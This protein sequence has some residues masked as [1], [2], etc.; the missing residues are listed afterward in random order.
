MA[1]EGVTEQ[2]LERAKTYLTGAYPLRFDGNER[3][4]NILV[5][6][7]LDDMPIDYVNTRNDMVEAVTLDD[8]QRVAA[9]VIRPEDLH[10]VVVGKPQGLDAGN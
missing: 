5:G 1:E 7:Q 10:F 3:I 8:V 6:M 2:E 4:A 9:E